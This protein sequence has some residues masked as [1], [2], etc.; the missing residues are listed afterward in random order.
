MQFQ[1]SGITTGNTR[2]LTIPDATCTI[3]GHNNTQTLTNKTITDSTNNVMASSLK[4]ATTTVSV[5][6]ATAPSANQALIA[7]NSTTATWQQINHTT[8]SNIGTNTHATID[9]FLANFYVNTPSNGDIL[10]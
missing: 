1:L 6:S 5:S 4:S 2:V 8:L 10:R 7:T 3:V 9:T